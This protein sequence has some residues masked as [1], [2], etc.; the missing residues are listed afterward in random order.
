MTRDDFGLLS[1]WLA[2][3]HVERWWREDPSPEAVE[4]NY[5]PAVDG[6]DPTEHF[7]VEHD[8]S[9]IGMIQRY[10]NDSDPEWI[11][12]LAPT[13]APPEGAGF[14]YLIGHPALIGQGL[15]TELI[16][17]FVDN[18]WLRYPDA[19]AIVV[20]VS[21]GNRRSWRVLEKA[22]F[23]RTWTGEIHSGD[24][25]DEGISYCYVLRRPT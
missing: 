16:A 10:R 17:R 23:D 5:G 19:P 7:I 14:D 6:G 1:T 13:G 24:P 25:S 3:P 20:T 22:G 12:A 2:A 21:E 8:G 9:P 15:G 4:A 18:T 11:T